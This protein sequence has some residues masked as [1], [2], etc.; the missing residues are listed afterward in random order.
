MPT[1]ALRPIRLGDWELHPVGLEDRPLFEKYIRRTEYH[2]DLWSSNFAY[3]WSTSRPSSRKMWAMVDGMLVPFLYSSK[4]SLYLFCLPFGP[5]GPAR[6]TEVTRRCLH[7][8]RAF[9]GGDP[10]RTL[11]RMVNAGQLKFL[12]R[13]PE[14]DRY[15]RIVPWEGI[16]QHYD[17][18]KLSALVGREFANIRNRVNKF[19]RENPG[20][21]LDP[22][23][24]SDFDELLRLSQ[25]WKATSGV[26]YATVFD[27]HYFRELLIHGTQLGQTTLVLRTNGRVAGMVAGS[28]L[29]TGQSWGSVV[30]FDTGYPG[31]SE[32]LIVEFARYLHR[33][34]PAI[35]LMNVG[36]DLGSGGLR[37]YK[38]KFQPALSYKRYQIYFRR[39]AAAERS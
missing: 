9:N 37:G 14:F 15:F 10:D 3:I 21:T 24:D 17:V 2:A 35:R 20:F 8:C 25:R 30:K 26:K 34:D 16:E 12:R 23:R 29:P 18:P 28:P 38:L 1:D 27:G 19:A 36:S 39:G 33:L 22:Y 7:R 13:C 32:T 5:G 6:V 4:G 11:V 31:L